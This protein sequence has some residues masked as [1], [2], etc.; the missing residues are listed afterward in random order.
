MSAEGVLPGRLVEGIAA[1]KLR[2]TLEIAGGTIRNAQS[3]GI[4]IEQSAN[5]RIGNMTIDDSGK[6]AAPCPEDVE[7]AT[8]VRCSA[9]LFLRHVSGSTFQNITITGGE[10]VGIN[11]NNLTGS[12]FEEVHLNGTGAHPTAPGLLLQ[13]TVGTVTLR[14]CSIVD[15]SG[16]AAVIEQ[17]FNEGRIAFDQTTFAAPHRMTASPALL[18]IR[19]DGAAR[20]AVA[21]DGGQIV[22][23]AGSAII[24]ESRDTSSLALTFTQTWLQ[25]LG[26]PALDMRVGAQSRGLLSTHGSNVSVPGGGD[27][28]AIHLR[29]DGAACV[30]IGGNTIVPGVGGTGIRLT[31][32][33]GGSVHVVAA[34][35]AAG[36]AP[37]DF[38]AR[39]NGGV[40]VTISGPVSVVPAC[41]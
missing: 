40:P 33:S 3:Y 12:T 15:A 30:D 5:V 31:A 27:R 35:A 1:N 17:R 13:E 26:T 22:D 18:H 2:G 25:R 10:T 11:A 8:N 9:A 28:P 32:E 29:S 16:G 14:R 19:S 4:R 41:P 21:F 23:S 20:L 37:R 6:A 24:A 34:A 39:A 38:L 7:K 36:D